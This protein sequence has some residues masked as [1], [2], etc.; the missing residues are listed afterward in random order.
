[1]LSEIEIEHQC[2]CAEN[3]MFCQYMDKRSGYC[4]ATSC[5][6][7]TRWLAEAELERQAQAAKERKDGQFLMQEE[8]YA[9]AMEQI[10]AYGA[11]MID[12]DISEEDL[13][14]IEYGCKSIN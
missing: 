1:M 11:T 3:G 2:Y 5:K 7:A 12:L 4:I 8:L 6:E 10:A 9:R 13:E 14:E